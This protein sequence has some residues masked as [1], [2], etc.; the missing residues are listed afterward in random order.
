MSNSITAPMLNR[1]AYTANP[2]QNL[3]IRGRPQLA[4]ANTVPG[5]LPGLPGML[6]SMHG[7]GMPG[8]LEKSLLPTAMS[9]QAFS[10][11]LP[12][13][14]KGEGQA[15]SGD[16]RLSGLLHGMGLDSLDLSPGTSYNLQYAKSQFEV[17]YQAMRAIN[18]E[19]GM[20]TMQVSF[21]FKASFEYLQVSA[22]GQPINPD[23]GVGQGEETGQGQKLDPMQQIM[24]FFSPEKTSRRILDFALSFFPS[25][26]Q[27]QESGD[28]GDARRNFADFIGKAIQKGFDQAQKILGK[29]PDGVQQDIDK[30]HDLVFDGLDD[31]VKNGLDPVKL[32]EGG[33]YASIQTYQLEMQLTMTYTS[34]S[35]QEIP[36]HEAPG[37]APAA[38]PV[39]DTLV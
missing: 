20:Q 9:P 19:N 13:L 23:G 35:A 18:T 4:R 36:A 25:S 1:L 38:K 7:L 2:L 31:F 14:Q 17:N 26:K 29:L 11:T 10:S 34:E 8:G 27:F 6:D 37:Q 15:F 12:Q 30:T 3:K 16:D 28:T 33:I 5:G 21:S 32:G 22:G 24:D 39:L